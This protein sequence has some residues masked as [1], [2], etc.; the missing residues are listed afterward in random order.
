[1]W[2]KRKEKERVSIDGTRR[3]SEC[4]GLGLTH[5]KIPN[6]RFCLQ[7]VGTSVEL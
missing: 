7:T 2:C 3:E 1:M 6:L 5:S 4:E